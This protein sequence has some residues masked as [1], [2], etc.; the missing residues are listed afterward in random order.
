MLFAG[1]FVTPELIPVYLRWARYLCTLTYAVR[2]LL[3][4]EFQDCADAGIG[5]CR[6]ILENVEADQDETWWNWLVLIV[7]F[8]FFRTAA[9]VVLRQ[10]ATKF[11]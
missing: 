5:P 1:F 2:I 8:V 3:V 10:K 11:Y 7:L 4:M 6:Q 9:F